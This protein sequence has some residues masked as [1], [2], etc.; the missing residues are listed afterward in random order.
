MNRVGKFHPKI[1][2]L[3]G[4]FIFFI[5]ALAWS[6]IPKF[7]N[8]GLS[9]TPPKKITVKVAS[10]K[11]VEVSP[12]IEAAGVI[13]P[14]EKIDLFFKVPGRI[15]KVY[16]EEGEKVSRGQKLASLEKYSFEQ[17]RKRQ[18]A[19]LDS[20]IA[21][22]KLSEEKFEKAKKQ[23]QAKF[24]EIKKQTE[25][26][27]RYREEYEKAKRTFEAKEAVFK[28]GAISQE[29]LNTSRIETIAR[30]TAY[31]N[32]KRDLD[33]ISLGMTDSDI[34]ESGQPVPKTDAARL[35]ILKEI[36]TKIEKAETEVAKAAVRSTETL[37][38]K[39]LQDL[40]ESDL[41][42]PMDGTIMQKLKSRGD[43]LNGASG[44]GQA[45][46][47]VAK[48]DNIFAV[49]NV[50]E[51]DSV[52]IKKG[53]DVEVIADVLPDKLFKGEIVRV[54]PYIVEKTHTLQ[55]SAKVS[56]KE[57]KLRPGM[58]VRTRT[59]E[60]DKIKVFEIPRISFIESTDKE[61]SIFVIREG[62]AFKIQVKIKETRG[63]NIYLSEGPNESD[64]VVIEGNSRL[65][66]GSEVEIEEDPPNPPQGG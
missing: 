21:Q 46:L 11:S 65:K 13:E 38:N 12:S 25:L 41:Y 30:S 42:S 60:G 5:S 53:L 56:N 32:G 16:V 18:E 31:E 26:V 50:N 6:V 27:G 9:I 7:K 35:N 14:E 33:I 64:A 1:L 48:I 52:R 43:V 55:V 57:V 39:A 40:K 28:E 8:G 36:N 29:E 20:A 4:G 24:I 22:L 19:N 2:L 61:G 10:I 51:K 54:Q 15:E 62:K 66:E 3:L 49:Y 59:F 63:D 37:L 44:Q 17:E 58:F 45:V 47:A 23:I 34:R